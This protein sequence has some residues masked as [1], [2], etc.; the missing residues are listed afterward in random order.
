[1]VDPMSRQ[2][3]L[4]ALPARRRTRTRVRGRLTPG[5]TGLLLALARRPGRRPDAGAAARRG[6][7]APGRRLRP[8]RRRPRREP[9]AQA[10]D[11][12]AAA[13]AHRDHPAGRLS[14][15][16]GPRTRP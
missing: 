16:R 8:G 2:Y 5:E 15:G 1:M 3:T 10:R 4:R 7:A 6:D 9:A 13:V 11:D 12:P 14:A